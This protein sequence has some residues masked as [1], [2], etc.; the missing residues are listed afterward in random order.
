MSG[1]HPYAADSLVMNEPATRDS[2]W[3]LLGEIQFFKHITLNF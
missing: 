2:H 1:E 3:E